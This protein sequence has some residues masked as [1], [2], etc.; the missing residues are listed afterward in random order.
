MQE[1]FT[2]YTDFIR[3]SQFQLRIL[4]LF[5]VRFEP[6][7]IHNLLFSIEH[8][9]V[10]MFLFPSD[11]QNELLRPPPPGLGVRFQKFRL[12]RHFY[13]IFYKIV[14]CSAINIT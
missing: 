3:V 6:K 2:L 1:N 14:H 5:L 10:N 13:F 8:G 11:V 12:G 7:D 9:N 4:F